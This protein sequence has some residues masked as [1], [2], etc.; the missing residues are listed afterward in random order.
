MDPTVSYKVRLPASNSNL[1]PGFDCFGLALKLYL[2]IEATAAPRGKEECRVRTTGPKENQALPGNATNLIY[3]AMKYAAQSEGL[4]LPPV[5]LKVHNEIPLASG[6]G[7]SAAAIVGGIMLSGLLGGREL[8]KETMQNYASN[9]EGH[10]D[11][12]GA[13]IFGGFVASCVKEPGEVMASR[14]V[15]PADV[16]VVVVSPH[17]QLPTHVA[18]AA[19]PK[20][21]SRADAVYN[22][23]RASL[24]IGAIVQR[25]YEQ[26]WDAMHDRLHQPRRESL[27]PGLAEVL[28]LPREPGLLGLALSG[29]GPSVVALV[30]D[31]D[32]AIGRKI[33]GCFSKHQIRS[34]VRVLE[35]DSEGCRVL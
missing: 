21:V 30:D 10:P 26:L 12:V 5:V 24:F 29:A 20:T 3:R 35:V 34:K 8:S 22:L 23:Q 9:F 11:N 14:F 13:A 17:T 1:G 27:V 32:A 15:W 19:L 2:T 25:K 18:R 28:A 6:L 33:A 16:R 4:D 31:R 7:S